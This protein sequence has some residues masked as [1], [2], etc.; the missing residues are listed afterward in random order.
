MLRQI[1]STI[2]H[3]KYH[4]ILPLDAMKTIRELRMNGKIINISSC[5]NFTNSVKTNNL[6]FAKK[7]TGQSGS[8]VKTMTTIA[9]LNVRSIKNKDQL[10]VNELNDNNAD[11]AVLTEI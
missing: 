9:T 7:L 1:Q 4:K 11:I 2:N 8:E 3:G 5:R 10:K 6:T